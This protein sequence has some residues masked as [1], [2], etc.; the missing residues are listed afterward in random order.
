[1]FDLI[2]QAAELRDEAGWAA[3]DT[4]VAALDD[5]NL[6]RAIAALEQ[7]VAAAEKAARPAPGLRLA[8]AAC[9]GRKGL[10][11]KAYATVE[12]AERDATAPGVV[13]NLAVIYGRK[14]LLGNALEPCTLL[15]E[16]DPPGAVIQVDGL[17]AGVTPLRLEG[18]RPGT[19]R[20]TALLAG[21]DDG[22]VEISGAAGASLKAQITL[23]AA[24]VA[25]T[26]RVE[27]EAA[28]VAVNGGEAVGG[29]WRGALRPGTYPVEARLAGYKT[30]N[31]ALSVPVSAVPREVVYRLDPCLRL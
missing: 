14:A 29:T 20:V 31:S 25:Y 26:V 21:Y 9:Y 19:H 30:L 8:L 24:P 15:M 7:A 27:P 23:N 2:R 18:V 4:E 3:L 6:N 1:L 11:E 17:V 5:Q 22:A 12:A 16:S 28:L 10:A 13:F